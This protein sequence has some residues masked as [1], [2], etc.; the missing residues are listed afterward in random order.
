MTRPV[1]ALLPDDRVVPAPE[2]LSSQLAGEAILLDPEG[3]TYFALN[4]VAARCWA[5]LAGGTERLG[6]VH[7]RLLEEYDVESAQL[8]RDLVDLVE[9]LVEEELVRVK[10]EYEP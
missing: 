8:W 7:A 9:R 1:R 3:G 6:T 5:L 2:I 4:E 10:V